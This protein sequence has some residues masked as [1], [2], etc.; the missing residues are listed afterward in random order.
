MNWIRIVERNNN[1]NN[2]NEK[3]KNIEDIAFN[4]VHSLCS[5]RCNKLFVL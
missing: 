3:K 5:V 1:N 2:N 4:L